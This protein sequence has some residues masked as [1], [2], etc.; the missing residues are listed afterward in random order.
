VIDR[1]LSQLLTEIDGIEE[2]RGVTILA[3]T[4]R[5]DMI[6]P[7]LL[8]SGRL[9]VHLE[10]PV[11]DAQARKA[12]LA[13]HLGKKPVSSDFSIDWLVAETEGLVGADLESIVRGAALRVI[14]EFV[15]K[16]ESDLNKFMIRKKHFLSSLKEVVG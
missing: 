5:L 11:P 2:L 3:A 10:L 4:N 8:R 6:D 9:E 16:N 13:I 7:A 15:E 12:I 14:S 1:V